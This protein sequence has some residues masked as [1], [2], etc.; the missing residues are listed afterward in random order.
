M[1]K[2]S[3]DD[4]YNAADARAMTISLRFLLK[5]AE[6]IRLDFSCESSA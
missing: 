3:H 6:L 5:T 1:S 4:R 2:F